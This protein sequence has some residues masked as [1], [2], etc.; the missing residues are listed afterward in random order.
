MVKKLCYWQAEKSTGIKGKSG[1]GRVEQWKES[2]QGGII[3]QMKVLFWTKLKIIFLVVILCW[4]L[5]LQQ[6][7]GSMIIIKGEEMCHE[8]IH[9]VQT[10]ILMDGVSSNV[11]LSLC[12]N[13]IGLIS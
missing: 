6:K 9:F 5:M 1:G 8:L 7:L 3:P 13:N 12:H 11:S 10:A 2:F 4:V